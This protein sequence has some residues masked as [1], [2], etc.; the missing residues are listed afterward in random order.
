VAFDL[1]QGAGNA[2]GI[3]MLIDESGD[4]TYAVKR[5]HNTQGYGN[6]RRE[7]GSIGVLIDLIGDDHYTSGHDMLF[8]EKGEHGI[9]IDWQ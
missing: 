1:S 3:G 8:W 6:F 2:N 9:G 7:Y 5:L 4:D